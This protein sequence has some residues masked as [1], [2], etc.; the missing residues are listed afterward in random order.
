[1]RDMGILV[2]TKFNLLGIFTTYVADNWDA[3]NGYAHPGLPQLTA[4][5]TKTDVWPE[6]PSQH[7]IAGV[8]GSI[9]WL[10]LLAVLVLRTHGRPG[11]ATRVEV[12]LMSQYGAGRISK[13]PK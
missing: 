9:N 13:S 3:L 12:E 7:V 11:D 6:Y 4:R 1:M 2:D 5:F 10:M 8:S